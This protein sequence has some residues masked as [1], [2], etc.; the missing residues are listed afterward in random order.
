M[1]MKNLIVIV[2]LLVGMLSIGFVLQADVGD[3]VV[4]VGAPTLF[5]ST[6]IWGWPGN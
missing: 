4:P 2:A 1:K 5:A 6:H 3:R